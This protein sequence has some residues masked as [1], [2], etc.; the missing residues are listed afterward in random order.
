MRLTLGFLGTF[1]AA[2][3]FYQDFT[4]GFEAAKTFTLYAVVAYFTINSALTLWVW[5]VEAG[6][7]YVGKN[8]EG[9]VV[10]VQ[11]SVKKGEPVWYYKITRTGKKRSVSEGKAEFRQWFDDKGFFVRGP[12]E[13]LLLKEVVEEGK[14]KQ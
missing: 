12:L 8:K 4:L 10:K 6:T 9:E 1:L 2:L 13:A 5:G 14:K 11:T 3:T 7:V